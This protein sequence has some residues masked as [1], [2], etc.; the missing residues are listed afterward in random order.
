M[1]VIVAK[2]MKTRS[3]R[4]NQDEKRGDIEND[5]GGRDWNS[6]TAAEAA[7]E[8]EKIERAMELVCQALCGCCSFC[9]PSI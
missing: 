6:R 8:R 2:M 1:K 4:D 5:G 7:A 9:L 3:D